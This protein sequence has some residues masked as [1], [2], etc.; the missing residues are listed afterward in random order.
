[1]VL[2][3]K[4]PGHRDSG[5][6][7][8]PAL[9]SSTSKKAAFKPDLRVHWAR[10][11]KRINPSIPSDERSAEAVES[12]TDSSSKRAKYDG[13]RPNPNARLLGD[14]EKADEEDQTID[15]VVV[16]NDFI[17]EHTK[18]T[19]QQT[20]QSE[21]GG[22]P[23]GSGT[24]GTHATDADSGPD[25]VGFFSRFR[26]LSVIRFRL[27][28]I[29]QRFFATKFYDPAAEAHYQREMYFQ[30][31]TLMLWGTLFNIINWVLVCILIPREHALLADK[32]FYYAIA[33]VLVVPMP[34]MV[35]FD[36]P[37]NHSILW[38]L[39]MSFSMWVWPFYSLLLMRLCGT[40]DTTEAKFPCPRKDF[41]GIFYY[42]SAFPVI[43][44]FAL[45]QNRIS[46][47]ISAIFIVGTMAPVIAHK[48]TWIRNV[49]N[50][51]IYISFLLWIHYQR[52]TSERRL[53]TMRDR[54]KT[55]YRAT[56]KAQVSERKA[57]DSKKRFSSYIFHE[58]RV[59]LNTALLAVQNMDAAGVFGD[60][61]S[62]EFTALEGSLN[63]MSKV[64]NDVLDFNRMD[65]G[66]FESVNRPYSFHKVI[67]GI[68][69][70]LRLTAKARELELMTELDPR[71]DQVARDALSMAMKMGI[72]GSNGVSLARELMVKEGIEGETEGGGLVVGDEHRL[73]QIVTNLASNAAK[74]SVAGGK[75]FIRTKLIYPPPAQPSPCSIDEIDAGLQTSPNGPVPDIAHLTSAHLE[76]HD[77]SPEAKSSPDSQ[78]HV[79]PPVL[80]TIVIRLEIEDTGV[81]IQRKDMV[82]NRLFSPYVHTEIG[83]LQGGKG[84]GLGLALSKQI[85]RL[86]GGRFGVK[87]K[88]GV[89]SI[90][91][92]ELPVG[93][94]P[95]V[96]ERAK[97]D[98]KED[99]VA[100]ALAHVPSTTDAFKPPQGE[101]ETPSTIMTSNGENTFDLDGSTVS[102]EPPPL[103]ATESGA[104]EASTVKPS[105]SPT[106]DGALRVLVVDDDA[107]TRKLMSRMLTRLGCKVSTA[108][109]GK[110]AVD[111]ATT[112]SSEDGIPSRPNYDVIFLDNQMPVLSG[113]EVVA[114][115][116]AMNRKDFVVG[117]TGNALKEDQKEYYAAGVDYVLTKPVLERSL[118]SMLHAA[119]ERRKAWTRHSGILST[120]SSLG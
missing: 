8:P 28:A 57:A 111:M 23:G 80:E 88:R 59:P 7:P 96:I 101:G 49:V 36:L 25:D 105:T 95:K 30:T 99:M 1:M 120:S 118:K 13:F 116:R 40:F 11:K 86:S 42:T 91:W 109:N 15:E 9:A 82:D 47:T 66:R 87:S 12:T 71:I 48:H 76:S 65:A 112:D 74:F 44:L 6:L 56:Q 53:F 50:Y 24:H 79:P 37:R 94:G 77:A 69:V 58:V 117:V 114:Q 17:L 22:T 4:R 62:V 115:L 98:A 5:E 32:I 113:V 34:L 33:P 92:V 2:Q 41:V 18:S 45:G 10:F 73:R 26:L 93:V 35:I 20:Q 103:I 55:Q 19:T 61:E 108:E 54:L 46:Q 72:G 100:S 43:S 51:I 31:K 104:S 29:T 68:L 89:G 110:I 84:T 70:P 75:I 60:K 52:E 107:L 64:L 90:F 97:V 16:D 78:K 14:E 3:P 39:Y 38:Q 67:K 21:A 119:E 81:G 85:V 106:D 102:V 63:M 83:R 27:W